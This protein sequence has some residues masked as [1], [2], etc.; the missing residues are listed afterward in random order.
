MMSVIGEV[1]RTLSASNME[2]FAREL[3]I[4]VK[5]FIL[6]V[7]L[8]FLYASGND[9]L[10]NTVT[11]ILPYFDIMLRLQKRTQDPVKHLRQR[12]AETIES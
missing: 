1:Y 6:D 9:Q 5:T 8:G 4:F 11:E 12:F 7:S 2:P 10:E 3:T